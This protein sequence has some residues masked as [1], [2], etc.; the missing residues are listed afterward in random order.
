MYFI[1]QSNWVMNKYIIISMIF[2]SS[3]SAM[4]FVALWDHVSFHFIISSSFFIKMKKFHWQSLK[5]R[6]IYI[7]GIWKYCLNFKRLAL[8]FSWKVQAANNELG[9]LKSIK[10]I[11]KYVRGLFR[12]ENDNSLIS[13][14]N[15]FGRQTWENCRKQPRHF[16]L[17]YLKL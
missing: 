14:I 5:K 13:K 3:D 11:I 2:L 7:L 9:E 6:K 10:N 12:L 8:D 15:F 16:S 17:L 1:L 4:V